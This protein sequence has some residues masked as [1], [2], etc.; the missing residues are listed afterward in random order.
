MTEP[1]DSLKEYARTTDA[2]DPLQEPAKVPPPAVDAG[3]APVR[4]WNLESVQKRLAQAKGPGYWR[5]LDELFST[6]GF[7]EF[8][9][10]RV[11]GNPEPPAS[12]GAADVP[13][14]ACVLGL[15]DPDR[16]Q[17]INYLDEPR[18]YSS[19]LLVLVNALAR[20]RASGGAGIRILTETVTSPTL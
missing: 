12:L 11:E 15:Y 14:Q 5:S 3:L 20:Q 9:P 4:T 16:L 10:T 2:L 7:Q 1:I 13:T 6:N 18:T 17:S 19:F 8:L